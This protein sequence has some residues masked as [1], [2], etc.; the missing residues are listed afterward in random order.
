MQG[1]G[2]LQGLHWTAEDVQQHQFPKLRLKVREN[3]V[4]LAGG[5]QQLPIC[6]PEVSLHL[7]HQY[8]AA[9]SPESRRSC[10]KLSSPRTPCLVQTRAVHRRCFIEHACIVP[11]ACRTSTCLGQT[12]SNAIGRLSPQLPPQ[13]RATPLS[14]TQWQDMLR[15][16]VQ[17]A[18]LQGGAAQAPLKGSS[19]RDAVVLDVRN[20]YEWDAGHFVGAARP[21]EVRPAL[22]LANWHDSLRK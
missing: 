21:L 10:C 12:V 5:T 9:C 17:P 3:L 13:A 14:P 8:L 7:F 6:V 16:A 20:A 2:L 4:Q 11:A 19:S 22:A 18:T 1:F 15:R